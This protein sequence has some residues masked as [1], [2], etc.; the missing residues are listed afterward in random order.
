MSC[1]LYLFF[2]LESQRPRLYEEDVSARVYSISLFR[3]V[4]G[5]G[6]NLFPGEQKTDVQ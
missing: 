1:A 6:L 4:S 2:L 3:T 5:R